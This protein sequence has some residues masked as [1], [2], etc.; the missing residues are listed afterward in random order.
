LVESFG[1]FVDHHR[2]ILLQCQVD[3]H[4]QGSSAILNM[5]ENL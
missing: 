4:M 2:H 5:A 1:L 3:P